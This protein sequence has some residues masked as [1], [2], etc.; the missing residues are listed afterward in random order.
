ME[1]RELYNDLIGKPFLW[2]GRGPDAYDCWGLCAEIYRRLNKDMPDINSPPNSGAGATDRL[3]QIEKARFIKIG[4]PEPFCLV[5]FKITPPFVSHIGV[6]LNDAGHFI[7][8][9][10]RHNVCVKRMDNWWRQRVAG[11][12]VYE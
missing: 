6:V 11:F 12:Y 8:I 4:A 5:I 1:S 2:G 3:V 10:R 9:H 7:H